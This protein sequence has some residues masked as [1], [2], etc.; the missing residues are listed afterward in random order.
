MRLEFFQAAAI[1]EARLVNNETTLG[2]ARL[3]NGAGVE[4]SMSLTASI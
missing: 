1:A 3:A 4:W 2:P